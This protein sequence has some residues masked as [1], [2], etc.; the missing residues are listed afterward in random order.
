MLKKSKGQSTAEYAIIIAVVIGAAVAMQTYV[1]RGL[2]ARQK[3]GTDAFTGVDATF[4]SEVGGTDA[5]FD[6]LS[7]YEP[8]Y[9]ETSNDRYQETVEQ[10]HMGGGKIVKEKVSDV[11]ATSAGSIQK[12]ATATDQATRD[13]QWK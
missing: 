12:Q 7:Q 1:K 8:Y 4:T 10:E 2:Q 9:L 5:K 6:K 11:S 3:A 13:A